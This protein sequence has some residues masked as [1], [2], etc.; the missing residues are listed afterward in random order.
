MYSYQQVPDCPTSRLH[1]LLFV[2]SNNPHQK[3][4]F[5][6][7]SQQGQRLLMLTQISDPDLP[8]L[9]IVAGMHG[10]EIAGVE[11]AAKFWIKEAHEYWDQ[12]NLIYYPCVNPDGY[13]IGQ[14][15]TANGR[16]PNREFHFET[17]VPEAMNLIKSM[18]L[19]GK[20][21]D[22]LLHLHEDNPNEPMDLGVHD[23]P[24][25]SYLYLHGQPNHT[26]P[27]AD[28]IIDRWQSSGYPIHHGERLYGSEIRGGV[29]NCTA[30]RIP[31][32]SE[33]GLLDNFV[34]N[35]EKCMSITV[36]TLTTDEFQ[37]ELLCNMRRLKP[38][39][40]F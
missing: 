17:K 24:I 1:D 25:G 9:M 37:K 8:T 33:A 29:V 16:D 26:Y 6:G 39:F 10:D 20:A 36:E 12:V 18:N 4:N 35:G 40:A 31:H 15:L 13:N 38:Q 22:F 21:V 14:R 2:N 11:A 19:W 30:D 7:Y 3:L 23:E 32:I 27:I 5:Y 34:T 28:R